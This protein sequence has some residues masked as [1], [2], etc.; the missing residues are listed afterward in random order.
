VL[1]KAVMWFGVAQCGL[2]VCSGVVGVKPGFI[3]LGKV[4]LGS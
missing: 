4:N 1:G 3:A 2:R